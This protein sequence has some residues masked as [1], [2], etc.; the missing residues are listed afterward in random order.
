MRAGGYACPPGMHAPA[1]YYEICSMSGRYTSFW[2]AFLFI[3]VE[4][5]PRI[6]VHIG[7]FKTFH[8]EPLIDSKTKRDVFN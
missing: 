4:T 2:N 7:K 8:N 1:G 3:K 6:S 5:P